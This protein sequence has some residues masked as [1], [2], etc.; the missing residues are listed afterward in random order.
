MRIGMC[1]SIIK[2]SKT[3]DSI[4][5]E[6][7]FAAEKMLEFET[8]NDQMMG[9]LATA[10]SILA[11]FDP[12]KEADFTENFELIKKLTVLVIAPIQ[13]LGDNLHAIHE[14]LQ[15]H[16]TDVEAIAKELAEMPD[17]LEEDDAE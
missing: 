13:M 2:D 1:E 14:S 16:R 12:D 10:K 9:I 17:M 3:G 8:C 4:P 11:G 7:V 15:E 6:A 5:K